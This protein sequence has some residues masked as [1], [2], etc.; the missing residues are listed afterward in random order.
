[1]RHLLILLFLFY[2][3]LAYGQT[4]W[5]VKANVTGLNDGTT[6]ANAFTK[7]QPALDAASLSPDF[8][9]QIWVAAGIYK[10]TSYPAMAL[11]TGIKLFAYSQT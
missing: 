7:L 5:Y 9:R 6:W 10:P 11:Q 3:S 2:T 4:I 1:M 8:D